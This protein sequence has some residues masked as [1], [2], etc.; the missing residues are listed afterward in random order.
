[1]SIET[2]VFEGSEQRVLRFED[3]ASGARGFIVIDSTELGPA[4][5]GCRFWRYAT[6]D[7]AERDARRLAR[8]M[9]LK[10]ALAGLPLGGGKSVLQAP[11]GPFDRAA[12]FRAF[13]RE[14][15][16][17]AGTY[18]TAEDV[19]T[20]EQ[21]MKVI[22]SV[23]PYVFGIPQTPGLAG[24]DPSPWTALGV[25]NSIKSL[26][27]RAG[28]ELRNIRVAVQGLGSVGLHLCRLLHAD[29][30]ELVAA[31]MNEMAA[32]RAQQDLP[33]RI[34]ATD[35]IHKIDATIFAP[36]AL[37]ASLNERTIPEINAEMVVGAA[38]NQL[39]TKEDGE[40]L[41]K[42]GVLYAPDYIVNAGG[43]INVAAEYLKATPDEVRRRVEQI[44]PRVA[45]VIER[46]AAE[47]APTNVVADEMA[48]EIILRR[49]LAVA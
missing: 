10:N 2:S 47:G 21:D 33:I 44:G 49:A 17:C 28:R 8:G 23:S 37:G 5:G 6:G 31:D 7:E 42:H 35:E 13:A 11:T 1:M 25:F 9:S 39:A 48:R 4:L 46:A 38:N 45:S 14:L 41:L 22:R 26:T 36:C 34:V 29:G 32:R 19:G 30:A 27:S 24:G 12:V 3:P 40:R 20:T 18:L 15:N 16:R 43:V